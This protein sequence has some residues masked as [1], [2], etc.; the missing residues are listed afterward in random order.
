MDKQAELKAAYRQGCAVAIKAAAEYANFLGKFTGNDPESEK[1]LI[2]ALKALRN[3][4]TNV[5]SSSTVLAR[6]A[7][8]LDD[9]PEH[10]LKGM[11]FMPSY[12]A[13]PERG[14]TSYRTYRHPYSNMHLHKHEDQWLTHEDNWPSL[15]ASVKKWNLEN[16]NAT[17]NE[18]RKAIVPLVTD[19][20]RH[21]V[22]E[23]VPGWLSYIRGS[24]LGESGFKLP[25]RATNAKPMHEQLLRGTGASIIAGL[26]ARG[27]IRTP[28]AGRSVAAATGGA[29]AGSKAMAGLYDMLESKGV[30]KPHPTALSAAAQILAPILGGAAGWALTKPFRKKKKKKKDEEDTYGEK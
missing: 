13:V 5:P 6:H 12:I 26:A 7:L 25:G 3:R 20:A 23:G 4:E 21:G 28:G 15:S 16:P 18:R 24:I 19:A 9:L 2:S 11:G 8:N 1:V 22:Q 29:L 14:Q 17:F 27:L 10:K 30:V